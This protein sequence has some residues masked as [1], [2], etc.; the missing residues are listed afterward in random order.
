MARL[1]AVHRAYGW[2]FIAVNSIPFCLTVGRSCL[3]TGDSVARLIKPRLLRDINRPSCPV[4]PRKEQI[5]YLNSL[6][7]LS[8]SLVRLFSGLTGYST[9]FRASHA[10]GFL[11]GVDG[12]KLSS[13]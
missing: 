6:L 13:N 2:L 9:L 12:A 7:S 1:F 5:D 3:S 8:A 10:R 4:A 11:F